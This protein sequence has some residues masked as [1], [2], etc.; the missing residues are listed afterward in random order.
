MMNHVVFLTLI[1]KYFWRTFE[2]PLINCGII[3]IQAY[4]NDVL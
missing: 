4:S 2:I 1:F 3:P